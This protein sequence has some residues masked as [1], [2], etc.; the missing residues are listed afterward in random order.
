MTQKFRAATARALTDTEKQRIVDAARR[1]CQQ[2]LAAMPRLPHR[3]EPILPHHFGPLLE[4]IKI[5]DHVLDRVLDVIIGEKQQ[6]AIKAR[7]RRDRV[8]IEASKVAEMTG[9]SFH[10]IY[11]YMIAHLSD[12]IMESR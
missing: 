7:Q 6:R 8:C 12:F 1:S 4:I 11:W 5:R 3:E 9:G 2:A 10:E